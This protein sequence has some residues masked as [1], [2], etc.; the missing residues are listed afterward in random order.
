MKLKTKE[1]WDDIEEATLFNKWFAK[2]TDCGPEAAGE[3]E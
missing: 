2:N 3:E 1:E